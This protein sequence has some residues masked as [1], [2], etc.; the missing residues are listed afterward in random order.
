MDRLFLA[1]LNMSLTGAFVVAAICLARFA[2]QKAPKIISY[3][4]WAVAGFRFAFP[5]AIESVFSLIPFQARA[6]PQAVAAQSVQSIV[7][8]LQLGTGAIGAESLLPQTG[9]LTGA[10]FLQMSA[11]IG[12][13]AWFAGV[14]VM[15]ALGISSYVRLKYKL[16]SAIRVEGNLY[17]TDHVQ[18]PFVS[19][20][21]KPK[22]YIPPDLSGPEREYIILHERTHIKRHDHIVKIAAYFILCLHWFNPLAWVAFQL[23]NAD[24]EMSCDERVLAKLGSGIKKD[25]SLSL[26]SLAINRRIVGGSPLAFGEDGVKKRIKNVLG[27]KKSPRTVMALSITFVAVL[28]LGLA[29]SRAGPGDLPDSFDGAEA[30]NTYSIIDY[31]DEDGGY[32]ALG[33]ALEESDSG[34]TLTVSSGDILLVGDRR[35]EVTIDYLTLSFFTQPSLE[36]AVKWWA[37][38]LDSWEES[39]KVVNISPGAAGRPDD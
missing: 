19:G 28:S 20:V 31:Y 39:G 5:F 38:Y 34:R 11:A 1:I 4:L 33:L 30:V 35:Y 10:G 32:S 27:F 8:G 16:D 18:S 9:A 25:Y 17:E 21:F 12:S 36:Q 22:I 3:C 2:I 13:L 14:A 23:M 37:D 24:M 29:A 26:L 7:G 15:L 6:I